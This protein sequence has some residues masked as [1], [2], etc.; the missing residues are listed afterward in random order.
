MKLFIVIVLCIV[1]VV[2]LMSRDY[3]LTTVSRLQ[4]LG[5]SFSHSTAYSVTVSSN[6]DEAIVARP[7][8]GNEPRSFSISIKKVSNGDIGPN[9]SYIL[10]RLSPQSSNKVEATHNGI[11]GLDF[12]FPGT[13][14]NEKGFIFM[15]GDF[16]YVVSSGG[17]SEASGKEKAE[18]N[19]VLSSVAVIS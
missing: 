19:R 6:D 14:G 8:I 17:Y 11:S 12:D 10:D 18:F 1:A 5:V 16:L 2:A 9:L 4:I 15:D 7:T 3:F 13:T